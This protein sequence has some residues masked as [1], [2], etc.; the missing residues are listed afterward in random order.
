MAMKTL[1]RAFVALLLGAVAFLGSAHAQVGF[2][3]I[4]NPANPVTSLRET[5]VARLFLKKTV[6][7]PTGAPVAAVDQ[8]RTSSVRRVFSLEVHAKDPDAIVAHWQTMVFSGR[9]T[10]PP[11]KASDASVVDFV[12]A[13]PGAIGY[14]S[15]TA[16]VAGVKV[17]PVR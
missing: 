5:E 2:R 4:V 9:D 12:R 17:V 11:V 14:V 15:E 16:D 10:P 3:V 1:G 7:W 6:A 13:N 8:E